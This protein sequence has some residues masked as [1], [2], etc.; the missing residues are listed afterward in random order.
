MQRIQSS[1]NP[2]KL[3]PSLH[4][5]QLSPADLTE[6]IHHHSISF[7]TITTQFRDRVYAHRLTD[8]ENGRAAARPRT[9][10]RLARVDT[11]R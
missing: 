3:K 1:P 7:L 9:G 4:R 10:V 5:A 2:P 6:L 8:E 11:V